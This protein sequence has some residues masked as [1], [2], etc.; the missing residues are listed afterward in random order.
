MRRMAGAA[1]LIGALG[2]AAVFSWW[3]WRG[4]PGNSFPAGADSS[5]PDAAAAVDRGPPAAAIV[6][7]FDP[8]TFLSR[9]PA[10]SL[11]LLP[12][13]GPVLAT[14]LVAARTAHG[15][16]RSWEDVDRVRGIGPKTIARLQ[17]LSIR[18]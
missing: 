11:D 16:F 12:G 6:S 4:E 7:L 14:R 2:A 17:A 5:G 18:P 15:P 3:S 1:M 10:E 13:V 8:L 9:A